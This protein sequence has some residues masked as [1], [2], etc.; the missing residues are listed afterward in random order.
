MHLDLGTRIRELRRRDNRTQETL[1]AALGVTS[2]AVSRWEA[3]GSYPDMNLIPSIANYFGVTIDVLFGYNNERESRIEALVTQIQEMKWKNNGEDNCLEETVALARKAVA[4]YPGNE[5]LMVCLA[6]TLYTYGYSRYGEHHLTDEDGYDI[7]DTAR[8]SAYGVWNEAVALYEKALETLADGDFRR[9]AAGELTQLYVNMG[10]HEKARALAEAAPGLYSS[11]EYMRICACDGKER[12]KA[13][14]E[15]ILAMTHASAALVIQGVLAAKQNMTN[16]QKAQ[17]TLGAIGLFDCICV[18]GNYGEHNRLIARMYTQ[19]ALY[20]WLDNKRDE[21]FEALDKAL[22]SFNQFKALCE[23]EHPTYTAPLLR[24]VDVDFSRSP[25]VDPTQPE[26][27]AAGLYMSWPW[28]HEEEEERIRQE[29]QA[30]P[31]WAAWV[32]KC[33]MN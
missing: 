13:Y 17:A 33:D 20:L 16:G 19:L 32:H 11:R 23:A 7:Y 27:T 29:I 31:R 10:M 2:Q 15:A 18:D 8:H 12:A 9:I 28:W 26:T 6:S 30:D 14:S 25:T 1:A 5:K 24:L 22:D 3:G 4:E 21:A